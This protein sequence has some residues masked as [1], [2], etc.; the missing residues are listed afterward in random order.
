M[1]RTWVVWLETGEQPKG[2]EKPVAAAWSP[3]WE[4]LQYIETNLS[5]LL[6]GLCR[7]PSKTYS[8][9]LQE[10][11]SRVW[12]EHCYRCFLGCLH[13]C[14]SKFDIA[15]WQ[16]ELQKPAWLTHT[17]NRTAC[18]CLEQA[19]THSRV[20]SNYIVLVEFDVHLRVMRQPVKQCC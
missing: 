20:Y 13:C 19:V 1:L 2:A 17:M 18:T 11:I 15:E 6:R 4:V 10:G 5:L 12:Q 14:F 8:H 9:L 7:Q 3:A 16:D